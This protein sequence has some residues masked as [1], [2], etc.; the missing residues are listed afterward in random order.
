MTE[1]LSI[2]QAIAVMISSMLITYLIWQIF[3]W[4]ILNSNSSE[5]N[6]D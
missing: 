6:D 2:I 3:R 4:R 1:W 5:Q